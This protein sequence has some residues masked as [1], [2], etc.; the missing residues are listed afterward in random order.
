MKRII[1]LLTVVCMLFVMLTGCWMWSSKTYQWSFEQD[2][3]AVVKIQIID[4]ENLEIDYGMDQIGSYTVLNEL[5]VAHAGEIMD[6]ITQL[7]W[8]RYGPNL[9]SQKGDGILILFENGAFDLITYR[10]P[11]HHKFD[12]DGKLRSYNTY[13]HCQRDPF[14]AFQA[15]LVADFEIK[16]K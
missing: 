1:T 5:D 6:R 2:S 10:E 11:K 12:E 14:Y 15:E 9:S 8:E 7:E 3:S 16:Q 4:G 13:L